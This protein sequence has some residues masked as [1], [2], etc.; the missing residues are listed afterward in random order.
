MCLMACILAEFS[1]ASMYGLNRAARTRIAVMVIDSHHGVPA[2]TWT[3]SSNHSITDV[4]PHP[5]SKPSDLRYPMCSGMLYRESEEKSMALSR[6][7]V[8]TSGVEA[9]AE[10]TAPARSGVVAVVAIV[11]GLV[12]AKRIPAPFRIKTLGLEN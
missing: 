8:V 11:A 1:A 2:Y 4:G 7:E 10:L 3:C 12:E 9:V 5:Y 6:D